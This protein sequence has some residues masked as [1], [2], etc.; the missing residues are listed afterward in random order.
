MEALACGTAVIAFPSG[1]LTDIVQHGR[2]GFLVRDMV[3]MAEA[4]GMVHTL[5]PEECRAAARERFGADRMTRQYL[6][7][8]RQLAASHASSA[9][10]A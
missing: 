9:Q 4:I 8:Y 3:E 6:E 1:A 2:T 5:D 10:A 7:R